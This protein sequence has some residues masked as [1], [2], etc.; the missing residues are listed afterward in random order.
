[1]KILAI[2]FSSSQ[3]SAALLESESG[4]ILGRASEVGGR[5]MK[6]LGLVKRTLIVTGHVVIRV[7][8]R[9]TVVAAR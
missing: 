3:R 5:E 6:A 9:M 7:Q 1:M 8:T 4:A 2:E